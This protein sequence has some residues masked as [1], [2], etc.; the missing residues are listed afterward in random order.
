MSG[1]V[2]GADESS[3][4]IDVIPPFF[5]FNDHSTLDQQLAVLVPI[6]ELPRG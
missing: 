5:L 3:E 6:S 2:T 4:S 1:E